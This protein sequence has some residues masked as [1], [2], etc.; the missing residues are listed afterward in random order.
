MIKLYVTIAM[1]S[2][3]ALS[4]QRGTEGKT[5]MLSIQ[6]P[7]ASTSENMS[8]SSYSDSVSTQDF[9]TTVP[10][11]LDSFNCYMVTVG[12]PDANLRRNTCGQK[13]AGTAYDF[14]PKFTFG[15][16]IIGVPRSAQ[17]IDIEVPA[18]ADRVITLI[19]YQKMVDSVKCS[20]INSSVDKSFFS[21][22]YVIGRS[23]PTKLAPTIG[24]E[25][26]TV[27]ILM[28]L[29]S[30]AWFDE[31]AG[32]DFGDKAGTRLATNILMRKE[33]FPQTGVIV[34]VCSPIV[35]EFKS[36]DLF[37]AQTAA[38]INVALNYGSASL[39]TSTPMLS[40]TRNYL[41]CVSGTSD[42]S[43]TVPKGTTSLV[44]W[45]K[46]PTSFGGAQ[47]NLGFS[48][49]TTLPPDPILPALTLQVSDAIGSTRQFDLRG[50]VS[51]LPGVC[52]EYTIGSREYCGADLNGPASFDLTTSSTTRIFS[53]AACSSDLSTAVL[54]SSGDPTR[55][56]S[57][58]ASGT[59]L[60]YAKFS[61]SKDTQRFRVS[62][63]D[64]TFRNSYTFTNVKDNFSPRAV[65][66]LVVREAM[67]KSLNLPASALA[68]N[69]VGCYPVFLALANSIG[70]EV[71]TLA[72]ISYSISTTGSVSVRETCT[73][74]DLASVS[75]PAL[76]S[77]KKIYL[78]YS[79]S[80]QSSDATV[81]F[82]P[83]SGISAP[84]LN[85]PVKF[86]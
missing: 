25:F 22:P 62:T 56:L 57:F 50:P 38:D 76:V 63:A 73:G 13:I 46:I 9:S 16:N 31:C 1:I 29:D 68:V 55:A 54:N 24:S 23:A 30:N 61:D 70:A 20:D 85:L 53:D 33:T 52:Y 19:G 49:N 7:T 67:Y 5:T 74:T 27:K 78:K 35:V 40:S 39:G 11:S 60:F 14:T 71:P 77:S 10:T 4:C 37:G 82:T 84:S 86:Q 43:F 80:S 28:S 8:Y 17:S 36:G 6:I 65:S 18:G 75:I 3:L 12:G 64:N 32:T 15:P 81:T 48:L 2:L 45:V 51:A 72:A 69:G 41:S 58:G 26:T 42:S 83:L 21:K 47:V 79:G 44:R 34:D 66:Q 59:Y